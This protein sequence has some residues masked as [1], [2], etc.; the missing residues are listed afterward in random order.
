MIF[1]DTLVNYSYDKHT[2]SIM[3]LDLSSLLDP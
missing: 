1:I 2:Y 3:D